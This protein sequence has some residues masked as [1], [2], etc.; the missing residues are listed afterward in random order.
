MS[1]FPVF[2]KSEELFKGYEGAD[3]KCE[4][5]G[6]ARR[7]LEISGETYAKSIK[8]KMSYGKLLS[9]SGKNVDGLLSNWTFQLRIRLWGIR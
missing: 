4:Y 8:F 2:Q 9:I 1:F 3:T 6:H 5:T 7:R